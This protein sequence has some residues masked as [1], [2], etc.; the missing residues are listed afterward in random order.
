MDKQ[1]LV[2]VVNNVNEAREQVQLLTLQGYDRDRIYVLAHDDD[3]TD[4]AADY[5]DAQKIGAA[6]EGVFNAIAN[7]FRSQGDELRAKLKALDLSE[8]EAGRL[9]RE[10]DEGKIVVLAV[11]AKAH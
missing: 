7:V 5:A 10:L 11:E 6:E 4:W 2:R 1:P 9:E 8:A 3:K